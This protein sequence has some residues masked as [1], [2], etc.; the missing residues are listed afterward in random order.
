MAIL[1]DELNRLIAELRAN[2]SVKTEML[3]CILARN[4]IELSDSQ[5]QKIVDVI[6]ASVL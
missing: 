1:H 5:I 4:G 6:N 2:D 3:R